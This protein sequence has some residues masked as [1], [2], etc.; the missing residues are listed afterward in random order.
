[1]SAPDALSRQ[2]GCQV[3]FV[4]TERV[5]G[6]FGHSVVRWWPAER[7]SSPLYP[8]NTLLPL[9]HHHQ[10]HHHRYHPAQDPEQEEKYSLK[11]VLKTI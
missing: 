5:S 6:R 4:T 9:L 7:P 11:N 1:M 10:P 3:Y 2:G 8:V